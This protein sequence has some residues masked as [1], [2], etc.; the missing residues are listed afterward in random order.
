LKNIPLEKTY[1]YRK[2]KE[3]FVPES[4]LTTGHIM[5][6]GS[7]TGSKPLVYRGYDLN[8]QQI[9]TGLLVGINLG[10]VRFASVPAG[11]AP[12]VVTNGN[13]DDDDVPV[14][15]DFR[16][17][18]LAFLLTEEELRNAHRAIEF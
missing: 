8:N 6:P 12:E 1:D 14:R 2:F 7:S 3:L 9:K 4:F 18:E 11:A 17:Q 15:D 10:R 16:E 5:W 13:D